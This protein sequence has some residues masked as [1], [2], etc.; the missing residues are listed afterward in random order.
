MRPSLFDYVTHV[1]NAAYA[2]ML[3]DGAFELFASYGWPVARMLDTGGALRVVRLDLE[4]LDDAVAGD[5]LLVRSWIV[6]A[7]DVAG[8]NG[9]ASPS[10][11]FALDDAGRA[12]RGVRLLQTI[13]RL[14]GSR[15]LRSTS[16]WAWRRRPAILGG[17][18]EA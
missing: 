16:D 11:T 7:E 9:A 18:P 14:D 5:E 17:V 15:I 12:P 6:A 1:N 2:A 13:V 10:P 3:E 4:Y 8:D